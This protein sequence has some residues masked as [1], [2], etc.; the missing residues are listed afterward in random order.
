V[1]G[2][3]ALSDSLKTLIVVS[4]IDCNSKFANRACSDLLG[5][6]ADEVRNK[7]LFSAFRQP[8][9]RF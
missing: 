8:D 4:D 7:N 3:L 1:L 9:R 2:L 6:K 5:R